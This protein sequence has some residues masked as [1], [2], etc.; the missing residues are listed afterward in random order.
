MSTEH[1]VKT[2]PIAGYIAAIVFG[3]GAYYLVGALNDMTTAYYAAPLVIGW[4]IV[5]LVLFGK[6]TEEE[7]AA[8]HH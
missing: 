3:I 1:D 4:P 2:H 6:L 7:K 8:A 5:S